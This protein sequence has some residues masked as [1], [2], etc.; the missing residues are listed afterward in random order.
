MSPEHRHAVRRKPAVCADE[1]Q[2]LDHRL[3]YQ[4]A[5][6]RVAVMPR[7]VLDVL[8][9][10]SGHRQRV[11]PGLC[12]SRAHRSSIWSFPKERSIAISHMLT[13]L[14]M[15]VLCSSSSSSRAMRVTAE[16]FPSS[17]HTTTFVWSTNL[18]WSMVILSAAPLVLRDES[19]SFDLIRHP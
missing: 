15:I 18:T 14:S 2:P 4:Q 10:P 7:K 6:E 19:F 11:E 5:V 17:S 13:P 1:G 12:R 3:R 9:M 16:R 8:G